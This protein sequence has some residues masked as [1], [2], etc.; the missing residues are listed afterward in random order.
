MG[1][2]GLVSLLTPRKIVKTV[3]FLTDLQDLSF[4]GREGV[5]YSGILCLST[6]GRTLTN[7]RID[8]PLY[9]TRHSLSALA[10]ILPNLKYVFK[11]LKHCRQLFTICP[12][13]SLELDWLGMRLVP[14]GNA[15][16]TVSY[17]MDRKLQSVDGLFA[18]APAGRLTRLEHLSLSGFFQTVNDSSVSAMSHLNLAKVTF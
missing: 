11:I 12:C 9:L 1:V 18:T 2:L 3:I 4:V 10:R 6:L 17:M 13:R 16:K 8:D 7:L 5:S 14:R 15:G